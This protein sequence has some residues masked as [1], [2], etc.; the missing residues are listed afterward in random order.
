V[1]R[2]VMRIRL[3]MF[4]VL[5]LALATVAMAADLF[6]GTWKE[7]LAKSEYNSGPVPQRRTLKI[8]AQSDGYK[9]ADDRVELDGKI[10]HDESILHLDGKD[11]SLSENQGLTMKTTKIDAN[12]FLCVFKRD[13]K[14]IGSRRWAVSKD[15]KTLTWVM[16]GHNDKGAEVSNIHVLD[17]Q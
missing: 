13:G 11:Y 15:G 1:E 10:N 3:I 16:N 8:E 9:L 6:V 17:K 7:D 14:E 2:F 5:L 4:A 12:V